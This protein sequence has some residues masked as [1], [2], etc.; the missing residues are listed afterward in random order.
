MARPRPPTGL[1]AVLSAMATSTAGAPRGARQLG[2][3]VLLGLPVLV[4]TLG[5]LFAGGGRGTGFDQFGRIITLVYCE[6]VLPLALISLGTG[7]FG[8]EWASGTPHYVVGLPV[9]R[10]ALVVGRWLSTARWALVY[11]VPAVLLVYTLALANYGSAL[12][13]Y[14]PELAWVLVIVV[15]LTLAYSSVFI[16][17]GLALRRALIASFIYVFAIEVATSKLPQMVGRLSL[18]FHGRNILW[19]VTGDSVFEPL[20]R[21]AFDVEPLSVLSSVLWIVGITGLSLALGTLAL[22]HKEC[23]GDTTARDAA[24]T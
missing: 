9:P 15:A 14:L 24:E 22:R 4:L 11:V 2:L 19:Q 16:C 17:L 13:R 1:P 21:D 10:F 5:V 8:D 18:A 3:I 20:T 6:L 23:G 12:A 7:A